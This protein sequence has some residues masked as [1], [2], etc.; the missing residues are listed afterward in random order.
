MAEP[1]RAIVLRD[2]TLREGLDVPGVSFSVA[3]RIAIAGALAAAGVP[4][5][6]VV[7]PSRVAD[8]LPVARRI[9]SE[10]PIR[11]SGLVYGHHTDWQGELEAA[12]GDLDR[13]DL[14]MPLSERREPHDRDGKMARLDEALGFCRALPLEVGAGFPHSTQVEPDFVIEVARRA[15]R[16]GATRITIYDTN[17]GA[18]PFGVHELIRQVANE[19]EVPVFFHAHDDLGLATANAWAAVEGG[20]SGLDVTVNGLGDRAGNA[21]LEQVVILLRLH[22]RPTGVDPS[23]LKGLSR[24]VEASS[25][26]PVSDLAPVVGRHVFDHASPAHVEAPAE[27]EAFDPRL[28]ERER[29]FPG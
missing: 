10:I 4:E 25:G 3:D 2:A 28:V 9:R 23:A 26:V 8:D 14:L 16:S 6:E 24:L 7:A 20:A 29:I 13:V 21:S 18:E 5:V 12:A 11:V 15:A 19:V 17:G 27:F 1:G 22:G